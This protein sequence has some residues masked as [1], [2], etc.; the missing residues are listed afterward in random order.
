MK[1]NPK[2]NVCLRTSIPD[3]DSTLFPFQFVYETL[4]S[5]LT[6]P[7]CTSHYCCFLVTEGTGTLSANETVCSLKPGDLF[8]IAAGCA[9]SFTQI[10]CLKYMYI[11]FVGQNLPTM[12]EDYGVTGMISLF[13]GMNELAGQWFTALGKCTENNLTTLTKGLLY[14]A[15]ALLPVGAYGRDLENGTGDMIQQICSFINRGYGNSNLTLEYI[16]QLYNYH[17]N[18]ISRRFREDADCSFTEYLTQCRLRH[19]KELLLETDLPIQEIASGVGYRNALYFSRVFRNSTG[20]PP[21][22]FRRTVKA[23]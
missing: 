21:S 9:Y 7:K 4:P 23:K 11:S 12:L 10:Q 17:P 14:Y 5:K 3:A 19:A 22:E 1:K 6:F 18:Y 20:M 13:P 16:C 2:G 15:L 8:F